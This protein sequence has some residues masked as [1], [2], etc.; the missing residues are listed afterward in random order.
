M[1]VTEL[2]SLDS[3][4]GFQ[5][6]Q[7]DARGLQRLIDPLLHGA[8]KD[9]ATFL[10]GQGHLNAGQNAD[11]KAFR[12]FKGFLPVHWITIDFLIDEP[13]PDVRIK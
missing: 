12:S 10:M 3:V 13:E 2:R 7:G 8:R 6:Q 11:S 4:C 5:R 9:Q 1:N